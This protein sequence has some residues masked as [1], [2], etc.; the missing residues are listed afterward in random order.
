M[1]I[2]W[3]VIV[4]N[5]ISDGI[6][7]AQSVCDVAVIGT[8]ITGL[9]SAYRLHQYRPEWRI[10]IYEKTT[11]IGGRLITEHPCPI[12]PVMEFGAGRFHPEWHPTV[13]NTLDEF[14]IETQSFRYPRGEIQFQGEFS[15]AAVKSIHRLILFAKTLLPQEKAKLSFWDAASRCGLTNNEIKHVIS[16]IGYDALNLPGFMFEHGLYV[17][18]KHPETPISSPESDRWLA[19]SLGFQHWAEKVAA[20]LK[21]YCELSYEHRLTATHQ[22]RNVDTP[23]Y[24]LAF[25]TPNGLHQVAAHS[26]ICAVHPADLYAIKD[27]CSDA[28]MQIGSLMNVPLVKGYICHSANWWQNSPLAGKCITTDLPFRK[29]YFPVNGTAYLFY[30]DCDSAVELDTRLKSGIAV[31]ELIAQIEFV[32][33]LNVEQKKHLHKYTYKWMFWPSGVAF[34][35]KPIKLQN[36]CFFEQAPNFILCS[37]VFTL[38]PGWVEGSLLSANA[39]VNHLIRSATTDNLGH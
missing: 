19:P 39:A 34:W 16:A 17:M 5:E 36:A 3:D 33:P 4:N 20:H 7:S 8:G 32:L 21:N 13:K 15:Q 28:G 2:R 30:C 9:I 23:W 27:P 24:L 6:A 11:R 31:A 12:G 10:Q 18:L 22:V 26:V 35:D 1:P 25:E 37:D 14:E 38:E 29:L